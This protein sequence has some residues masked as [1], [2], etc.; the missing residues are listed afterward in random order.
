MI[1]K[2]TKIFLCEAP[3]VSDAVKEIAKGNK[4]PTQDGALSKKQHRK[5][6]GIVSQVCQNINNITLVLI[7]QLII[8]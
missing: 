2:M 3:C 1:N 6:G 4:M 7:V 8:L 5:Y